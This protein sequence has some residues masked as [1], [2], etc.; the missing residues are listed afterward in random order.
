[1]PSITFTGLQKV[2]STTKH[3]FVDVHLDF[4]N[5]VKR[6]IRTDVDEAAISNSIINLFNTLPGQNLL[7]PEY[8]LNLIQ[9]V[10][11]PATDTTAR[12]IGKTIMDNLTIFEPRVNVQGINIVV[13]PDE[14]TFIVT[15]SIVI[16]ALDKQ[17]VIPGSLSK[18]GFTLLT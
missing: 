5:P 10:F 11:A 4:D 9:Y 7:N 1:M 12:L 18:T 2:E 3:S 13:K 17:V 6:D 16:P 8:G 14:Q 15:L